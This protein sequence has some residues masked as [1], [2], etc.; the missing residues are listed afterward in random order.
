[1]KPMMRVMIVDD[2]KMIRD[3]LAH[4]IDWQSF[5]C[6]VVAEAAD[7]VAAL[8]YLQDHPID[9]VFTDIRMPRLDG[10]EFARQLRA[11]QPWVKVVFV[12]GYDDF[13][14]V[15][16]A[17]QM[18]ACDYLL[19]P[20][21]PDV[22]TELLARLDGQTGQHSAVSR[23]E[24]DRLNRDARMVNRHRL[25]RLLR[26]VTLDQKPLG[27]EDAAVLRPEPGTACRLMV[28]EVDQ[29]Y[30]RYAYLSAEQ[31]G[32][33]QDALLEALQAL[34]G[35]DATVFPLVDGRF[36]IYL[37]APEAS[38]EAQGDALMEKLGTLPETGDVIHCYDGGYTADPDGIPGLYA[39]AL[40]QREACFCPDDAAQRSDTR[41]Y[42]DESVNQIIGNVLDAVRLGD[43]A[44]CHRRLDELQDAVAGEGEHSFLAAQMAYANL[45]SQAIQFAV[46]AGGA[47][48]EVF[49]DP[50][51]EYRAIYNGQNLY[52]VSES[53]RRIL[54]AI[55]EYLRM[56]Q[57]G[58]TVSQIRK[59]K[60]YIDNHL[61][62]STLSMQQVAD[63][64]SM[65]ASYFSTEFRKTLGYTFTEYLMMARI[66]RAGELL[67]HS[68]LKIYEV[69]EALGYE[70]TTYF[71]TLF[72]RQYGVSPK[73]FRGEDGDR[74]K[75]K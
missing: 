6:D 66:Q 62:D 50:I 18:G 44:L 63:R 58:D 31:L 27:R 7:G 36:G 10:M 33:K 26:R 51:D 15:R 32:L 57:S 24:L 64:F 40:R 65:S 3:G 52:Q 46:S 60:R 11:G 34:C 19:K 69:A 74:D 42:A 67:K 17:L 72:K 5:N 8:E 43:E 4:L 68:K 55:I 71:S 49:S 45:Y 38:I 56:L 12:S 48:G 29:F 59:A 2:E 16:S 30:A 37:C 73:Q 1:M 22:L 53:M 20:L 35:E 21:D 39:C 61:G 70:N 14:L 41:L 9:L 28:A 25:Q 75:S 47:I 54:V 23:E 13:S